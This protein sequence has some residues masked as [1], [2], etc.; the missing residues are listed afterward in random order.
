M[1][2]TLKKDGVFLN[3]KG[4][5]LYDNYGTVQTDKNGKV[6]IGNDGVIRDYLGYVVKDAKGNPLIAKYTFDPKSSIAK[7]IFTEKMIADNQVYLNKFGQVERDRFGI[8]KRNSNGEVVIGPEGIIRDEKGFALFDSDSNVLRKGPTHIYNTPLDFNDISV[9]LDIDELNNLIKMCKNSPPGKLYNPKSK[10]YIK[11]NS[12]KGMLL[13]DFNK[14]C[15]ENQTKI[16]P[17]DKVIIETILNLKVPKGV[18]PSDNLLLKDVLAP[19]NKMIPDVNNALIKAAP[20]FFVS[21]TL[22]GQIISAVIIILMSTVS[23]NKD[24]KRKFI[25]KLLSVIS[26]ARKKATFIY[27]DLVLR[28]FKNKPEIVKLLTSVS[29]LSSIPLLVGSLFIYRKNFKNSLDRYVSSKVVPLILDT[30]SPLD[31][32]RVFLESSG[33]INKGD[34]VVNPV[35][36]S[37]E[38]DYFI[39]NNKRGIYINYNLLNKKDNLLV[40]FLTTNVYLDNAMTPVVEQ[41]RLV[42]TENELYEVKGDLYFIVSDILNDILKYETTYYAAIDF[43]NKAQTL[44]DIDIELNYAESRFSPKEYNTSPGYMKNIFK[45]ESILEF[46]RQSGMNY[47]KETQKILIEAGDNLMYSNILRDNL[48]ILAKVKYNMNIAKLDIQKATI[49]NINT[50]LVNLKASLSVFKSTLSKVRKY[51]PEKPLDFFILKKDPLEIEKEAFEKKV[52]TDYTKKFS[53]FSR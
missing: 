29:L 49:R 20:E 23:E 3:S 53:K 21:N 42:K 33:V 1:S 48:N 22:I 37:L 45:K 34:T 26:K 41:L 11:R 16:D 4:Q 18:Y 35:K 27:L 8:V 9:K 5:V 14:T 50:V 40:K 28:F 19:E 24:L 15:A 12:P 38:S 25:D 43:I 47:N 44:R 51:D 36:L 13:E 32:T 31:K 2:T 7:K 10:K 52:D 46:F 39:N 17:K 30:A 6:I